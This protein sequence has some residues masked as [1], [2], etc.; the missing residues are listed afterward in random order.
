MNGF[1]DQK[2]KRKACSR[3]TAS[4]IASRCSAENNGFSLRSGAKKAGQS[5][6]FRR[7]NFSRAAKATD[8]WP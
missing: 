5:N 1:H 3:A 6:I 8:K 2:R 7:S 4:T